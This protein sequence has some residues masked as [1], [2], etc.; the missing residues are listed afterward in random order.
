MV[1]KKINL[2]DKIYDIPDF[3]EKGVV[4]RDLT[5]LLLEPEY[6]EET[7][8]QML[9]KIRNVKFDLVVGI[10]SRGFIFGP[11]IAYK[12]KAGFIPVRKVGKLVPR[13]TVEETYKLEYGT[14]GVKVHADSIRKGQRV[15]IVDDLAATG[16]TAKATS[17]LVEKLGGKVAGL[18][19]L[20]ELTYLNPREI[21]KGYK[22]ISLIKF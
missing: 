13:K 14:D 15:L 21:L 12:R 2:R 11:I 17:K 4:F 6:L 20:N 19:F 5:P 10:D 7:I 1:V 8:R 3:P 22:V 9:E 18:L 16:G